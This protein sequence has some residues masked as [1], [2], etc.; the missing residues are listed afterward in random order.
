MKIGLLIY[1][2]I[3]QKTGGYLYDRKLINQIETEGQEVEII[4]ILKKNYLR[5]IEDNFR[6]LLSEKLL[7]SKF[8]VLLQDELCHPSLFHLNEILAEETDYPLIFIV[9]NLSYLTERK[10]WKS[11][12]H[13]YFEKI[14]LQTLDGFVFNSKQTKNSVERIIGDT[15]NVVA[16]PGR[17][18]INTKY[19]KHSVREGNELR[20]LFAGNILPNK[21]LD[22]LIKTI[23]KNK[24]TSLTI[25]GN[26]NMNIEYT[27]EI[28]KLIDNLSLNHRVEMNGLCGQEELRELY[29]VC[30]LLVVPSYYEGYGIVFNEAM[31]HG[32]PIIASKNAV[33]KKK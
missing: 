32:L 7:N 2:D 29:H 21:V 30:D 20:I 13:K 27:D 26:E 6:D 3:N 22:M 12:M 8:D 25:A 17:D 23:E 1:G 28:K 24:G 11:K 14:Y 9:H 15:S 10:V 19:P 33:S 16:T 18:H 5:N 4:S 31:G